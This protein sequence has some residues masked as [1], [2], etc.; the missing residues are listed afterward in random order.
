MDKITGFI[1]GPFGPLVKIGA[2]LALAVSIFGAGYVKGVKEEQEDQAVA[3]NKVLVDTLA[4]ARMIAKADSEAGM[5]AMAERAA[6]AAK[7][8]ALR[9]Q[10]RTLIAAKPEI[11]EKCQMD[12]EIFDKINEGAK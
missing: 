8:K 12:Q 7:N 4:R 5:K 3:E 9:D 2:Y 6:L 10:V 11:Y 1:A